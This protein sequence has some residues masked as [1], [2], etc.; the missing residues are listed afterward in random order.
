MPSLDIN[1]F[2]AGVGDGDAVAELMLVANVG[3]IGL[4][5][6]VLTT[7]ILP[8]GFVIRLI[9]VGVLGEPMPEVERDGGVIRVDT[10][11]FGF[12]S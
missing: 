10:E 7:D 6:A 5:P 9:I 2:L 11:L 4:T 8:S 1:T 12:G 3:A